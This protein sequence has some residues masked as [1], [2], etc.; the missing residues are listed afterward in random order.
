MKKICVMAIMFFLIT[1]VANLYSFENEST[2]LKNEDSE[3]HEYTIKTS[4][5]GVVADDGAQDDNRVEYG[6]G[7]SYGKIEADSKAYICRFGCEL[8]LTKT[9]QTI[10]V[11]PGDSVIIDKGIMKVQ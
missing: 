5:G 3:T 2:T 8:I 7:V 10:T 6:T 11:K 1:L 9:G 4:P